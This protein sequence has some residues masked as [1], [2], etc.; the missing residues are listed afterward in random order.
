MPNL[1][2]SHSSHDKNFVNRLASD[3]KNY[4]IGVWIDSWEINVGDSIFEKIETGLQENDYLGIVLSPTSIKSN[5][6]RK[7]LSVALMKELRNKSIKILPILLKTCE[8]PALIS[9]KKYADFRES[10]EKGLNGLLKVFGKKI[11]CPPLPALSNTSNTQNEEEIIRCW[12]IFNDSFK[13]DYVREA[14]LGRLI[15]LNATKY[16]KRVFSDHW[17]P[18]SFR[19]KALIALAKA[20][21][22]NSEYLFLIAKDSW[23]SEEFRQIALEGLIKMNANNYLLRLFE[24]NWNPDWMHK[25]IAEHLKLK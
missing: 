23:D 6:V 22:S 15:E 13:A 1:F 2:I 12:N 17:L 5:W 7:E 20:V 9:D 21:N 4:N 24:D 19:K 10:Y 11:K 18:L 25:R 14:V 3:L 16:L 8:I